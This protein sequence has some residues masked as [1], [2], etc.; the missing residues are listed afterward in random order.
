M[1]NLRYRLEYLALRG[2]LAIFALLPRQKAAALGGWLAQKI[3][4]KMG[5]NRIIRQN[6]ARAFP[7]WSDVELHET[8][9]LCWDNLGRVAAEFPHLHEFQT[10]GIE[11]SGQSHAIDALNS[12]KPVIIYSGH[13][14]NWEI[15]DIALR[16]CGADPVTLYRAPNNPHVDAWLKTLRPAGAD[17]LAP[18]GSDGARAILKTLKAKGQ[19]AILIDQKQ[20]DGIELSF[21]DHPVMTGD[22][23]AVFGRRFDALLL[24]IRIYRKADGDYHVTFEKAWQIDKTLD[25]A[26]DIRTTMQAVNDELEEIIRAHPA[27]WLWLH[28][29]WK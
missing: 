5:A 11:I 29:R 14:A 1:K 3:G 23:L 10:S 4:T 8:A 25:A 12:D 24:P 16:R 22:A 2:L 15:Q 17:R 28:K 9:R 26:T 20:N 13:L 18:K 6:L 21:F 27:Q 19:I 7:N